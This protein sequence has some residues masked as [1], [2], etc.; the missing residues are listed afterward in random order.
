MHIFKHTHTQSLELNNLHF[1][2]AFYLMALL[3]CLQYTTNPI[4]SSFGKHLTSDTSIY[5]R[6]K[7][8]HTEFY[9]TEAMNKH[10]NDQLNTLQSM[11][12]Y[13]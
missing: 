13:C 12:K 1:W 6:L 4:N 7:C 2:N 5:A 9:I 8:P 3:L 10:E 11:R